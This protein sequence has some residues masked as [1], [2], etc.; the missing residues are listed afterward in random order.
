MSTVTSS[1]NKK[2]KNVHHDDRSSTKR[3][4]FEQFNEI[5][6][7][8]QLQQSQ[9]KKRN[10]QKPDASSK[11]QASKEPATMVNSVNKTH[12][13]KQQAK[14]PEYNS[15]SPNDDNSENKVKQY[16]NKI[17]SD[18]NQE[19]YYSGSSYEDDPR[20]LAKSTASVLKTTTQQKDELQ[21]AKSVLPENNIV[22]CTTA[23]ATNEKKDGCNKKDEEEE[24]E[25]DTETEI[26]LNNSEINDA[27][28]SSSIDTSSKEKLDMKKKFKS[29]EYQ[30]GILSDIFKSNLQWWVRNPLFQQIKIIDES[31][32]EANGQIIQDALEKL[33]I[34]K[35]LKNINAYVNEIRRIIKRTMCSRRGYVKHEIC[36]KFKS[37]F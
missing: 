22:G 12:K 2:N 27:V 26:E 14:I 24:E 9:S 33:Q 16:L 36:E 32:L 29:G 3:P 34:D 30:T 20:T 28:D 11:Q 37:K 10:I 4:L 35:S 21:Q 7:A 31:H 25:E 23:K 19:G 15:D 5:V 6:Q 8:N 18:K 13:E 17:L 1:K